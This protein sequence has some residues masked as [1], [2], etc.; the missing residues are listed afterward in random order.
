[1]D[2]TLE[3]LLVTATSLDGRITRETFS[4]VMR[5]Y[6][7]L[8][9]RMTLDEDNNKYFIMPLFDE[10]LGVKK[11][12]LVYNILTGVSYIREIKP[13]NNSNVFKLL[14]KN[15]NSEMHIIPIDKGI[16][17]DSI[18]YQYVT[19][20]SDNKMVYLSKKDLDRSYAFVE[21]T[22][23]VDEKNDKRGYVTF[24]TYMP[25]IGTITSKN[26]RVRD[27]NKKL[28]EPIHNVFVKR[29]TAYLHSIASVIRQVIFYRNARDS[30]KAGNEVIYAP[31]VPITSMLDLTYNDVHLEVNH[32]DCN[33]QNN[34][35]FNVELVTKSYNLIHAGVVNSMMNY[36]CFDEFFRPVV[37]A[38]HNHTVLVK[39]FS[40]KSVVD[41][42]DSIYKTD[43]NKATALKDKL[44]KIGQQNF[45]R[46]NYK[47]YDY[48]ES[49]MMDEEY[50]PIDRSICLNYLELIQIM[51]YLGLDSDSIERYHLASHHF[52]MSVSCMEV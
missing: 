41:A 9:G 2:K 24:E 3:D 33:H 12:Q 28:I 11:Y 4:R 34:S 30:A 47:N 20:S 35:I 18:F 15:D 37:Y 19:F 49:G 7:A 50:N 26:K 38:Q 16:P 44:K 36:A 45:I 29:D 52:P 42:I 23:M 39:G 46:E 6:L 32:F 5:T 22:I 14:V 25:Q 13:L 48:L 1:M 31:D 27:E 17:G 21:K 8:K 40:S 51:N 10:N 43:S